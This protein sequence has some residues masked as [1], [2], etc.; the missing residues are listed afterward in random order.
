M[1]GFN[2]LP[3]LK[4]ALPDDPSQWIVTYELFGWLPSNGF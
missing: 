4:G 3:N 2:K 1:R